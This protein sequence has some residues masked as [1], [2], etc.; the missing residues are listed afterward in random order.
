MAR[1]PRLA[2][3]RIDTR[4]LVLRR[5]QVAEAD[6][7][8]LVFT[9]ELGLLTVAARGARRPSSKLGALEPVHTLRLGVDVRR[10]RD[11]GAL[12]EARIETARLGLLADVARL[13]GAFRALVWIR[14]VMQP[15]HPER[16]VF[17][18]TTALLDALD[19]GQGT[20][21]G[22]LAA[23]GLRLL[24]AL[25]YELDLDAC[26]RCGV[27]CP[28]GASA[29]VDVSLGGLVCRACGAQVSTRRG[30]RFL[31]KAS[32]RAAMRL[33]TRTTGEASEIGDPVALEIVEATFAAHAVATR[34]DQA[35]GRR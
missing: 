7:L 12:R 6:L 26:V 34:P 17:R 24:A 35:S 9:E 10:G 32:V 14:T 33:A 19:A 8:V 11:M 30:S 25:G 15:L 2:S 21:E 31:V 3:E 28:E 13:E 23:S 29:W 5:T 16:F 18:E 22:R 20:V 1:P 4:A 27:E